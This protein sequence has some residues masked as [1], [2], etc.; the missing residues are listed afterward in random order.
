MFKGI[1]RRSWFEGLEKAARSCFEN[2]NPN[3]PFLTWDADA[4]IEGGWY[5]AG[6]VLN[7]RLSEKDPYEEPDEI[8]L[9]IPWDEESAVLFT[10]EKLSQTEI[11][12]ARFWRNFPGLPQCFALTLLPNRT[13][14]D[15]LLNEVNHASLLEE[16]FF[17]AYCHSN[18]VRYQIDGSSKV[19][20]S[21]FWFDSL[22]Q[23]HPHFVRNFTLDAERQRLERVRLVLEIVRLSVRT[24]DNERSSVSGERI[25]TKE[26]FSEIKLPLLWDAFHK[27][28]KKRGLFEVPESVRPEVPPTE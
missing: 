15:Y 21:T 25:V 1:D 4:A 17:G 26:Y 13:G 24:K 12:L 19:A 6:Y 20:K 22:I 10:L 23:H 9:R 16:V 5:H 7:P 18:N 2:H 3:Q 14:R 11:S 27:L 8:L 28:A